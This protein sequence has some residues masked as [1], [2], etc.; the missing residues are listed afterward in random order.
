MQI[1]MFWLI[2]PIIILVIDMNKIVERIKS[3][4]SKTPDLDIKEIKISPFKNIYVVFLETICDSNKIND[5]I[6]KNL[7]KYKHSK[8]LNSNLPGP[9]TLEIKKYDEIEFFLTNGFAI[10]ISGNK[11]LA[12]EVKGN[13]S[14]GIS[15]STREPSLIG[16]Q[17]AFVE[18]I[19]VNLGLIKRRIKTSKLKTE[20][21]VIGRD[22]LTKIGILYIENIAEYQNVEE[23]KKRLSNIDVDG[24][25]DISKII[26]FIENETAS[27]FPTIKRTERPDLACDSLLEGKIVLIMDTSPYAILLPTFLI[28]YI[29]PIN[30]SY[31]KSNNVSFIKILRTLCFII[32]I[33]APAIFI[34]TINYN[35]EVIPISLLINFSKQRAGVPF[36]S[37]V[38][39]IIMLII[40]DILRESDLRFPSSFGSAISILG[41]LIIGDAAVNAGIVSPIMIIISSLTFISSLVFTE[42]ELSNALRQYR[43]IFLFIACFFGIYG[44][45]LALM[46]FLINIISTKSLNKSFF[47]PLA[48]F[49]KTYFF[50]TF[51][52]RKDVNNLKRSTL[53][54]EKNTTRAKIKED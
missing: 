47:A 6:L 23:I 21:L 11:I 28:D 17:D 35:Q 51:F 26:N 19:Q 9:N 25:I 45:F 37:I 16:P 2:L 22:T 30:D 32:S 13:L 52:K 36:P 43:Y 1:C 41:A 24:I 53:I 42:L 46:L 31:M 5:Y 7:T 39:M 44:I 49:N 54:T 29:N 48:P 12:I 15:Q 10:I 33:S 38:E 20:E 18:N 14:R 27:V 34:A 4:F 3:E 40:C 50:K 8:N